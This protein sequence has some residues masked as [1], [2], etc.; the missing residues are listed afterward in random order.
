MIDPLSLP[1]VTEQDREPAAGVHEAEP[2][3]PR[4][5]ADLVTC[6]KPA[7]SPH[8]LRRVCCEGTCQAD[9]PRPHRPNAETL[10]LAWEAFDAEGQVVS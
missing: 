6:P 8:C 3:R 5:T 7:G 9:E 4:Q 1:P 2:H 10:A